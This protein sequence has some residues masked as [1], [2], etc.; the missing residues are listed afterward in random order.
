MCVG[1][2]GALESFLAGPDGSFLYLWL[3][4]GW[5]ETFEASLGY[6]VKLF[7]PSIFKN[8]IKFFHLSICGRIVIDIFEFLN[9]NKSEWEGENEGL[10]C[11]P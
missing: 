11:Y 1:G 7:T 9:E 6:T 4:W 3:S 8:Y 2:R 5:E 10:G